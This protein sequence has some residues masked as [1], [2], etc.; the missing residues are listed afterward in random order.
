MSGSPDRKMSHRDLVHLLMRRPRMSR[1]VMALLSA[2]LVCAVIVR[3]SL[4]T[5]ATAGQSPAARSTAPEQA[6]AE[7]VSL[8]FEGNTTIV[9]SAT[10]STGSLVTPTDQNMTHLPV[11]CR[12]VSVSRPPQREQTSTSRPSLRVG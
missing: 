10:V 4:A 9:A 12:V 2:T 1:L 3:A 5:A 8:A 7:L 11:F 6:C